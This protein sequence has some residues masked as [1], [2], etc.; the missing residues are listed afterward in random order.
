MRE[1]APCSTRMLSLSALFYRT[2]SDPK[3][4]FS[5]LDTVPPSPEKRTTF[6]VLVSLLRQDNNIQIS[7][8]SFT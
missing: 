1:Q 4:I 8:C 6:K 5:C 2:Q 3:N 7:G